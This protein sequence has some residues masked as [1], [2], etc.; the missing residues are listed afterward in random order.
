MK[1]MRALQRRDSQPLVIGSAITP[2][3]H[4]GETYGARPLVRLRDG[5][6]ET[7]AAAL[8]LATAFEIGAIHG[9]VGCSTHERQRAQVA[10][11]LLLLVVVIDDNL[12]GH[13]V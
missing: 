13:I 8:K 3:K 2:A 7:I 6:D 9:R 1:S 10:D 4:R 5:K 11:A 12:F